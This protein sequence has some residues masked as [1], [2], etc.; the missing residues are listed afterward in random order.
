MDTTQPAFTKLIDLASERLGGKAL[1]CS[2]AFFA[3]KEY[4]LKPGRGIFITDKY[5]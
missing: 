4:I 5:T 1:L 3:A 2:D